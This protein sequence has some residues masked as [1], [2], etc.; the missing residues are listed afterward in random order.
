MR[1]NLNEKKKDKFIWYQM[2]KSIT[3]FNVRNDKWFP[4]ILAHSSGPDAKRQPTLSPSKSATK[5]G[6]IKVH[7]L[8]ICLIIPFNI[9]DSVDK[10][11]DTQIMSITMYIRYNVVH[12][13]ILNQ[14]SL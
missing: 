8:L 14:N 2:I 13:K 12:T 1:N 11:L 9:F 10:W 5:K 7:C 4:Q 3:S 6:D